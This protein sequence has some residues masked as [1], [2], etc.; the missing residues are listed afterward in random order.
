MLAEA[1]TIMSGKQSMKPLRIEQQ[2]S[3]LKI[4]INRPGKR[5]A[6]TEELI[7]GLADRVSTSKPDIKCVVLTAC[8]EHFSS[9]LDLTELVLRDAYS[10][11]QHA[12]LWHRCLDA[13]QYGSVPVIAALKG[14]V[15]GGGLELA[16]AAHI[17]VA[18]RTTFYALPEGARGMYIGGGGSARIPRLIGVARMTDMML[19]GRVVEADEGQQIGLSQYLVDPAAAISKAME[20]ATR[21]AENTTLTNFA[22]TQV[23]PRIADSSPEAGLLTESLIAGMAQSDPSAKQRLEDFL[24]GRAARVKNLKS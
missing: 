14:A 6:L 17:R 11:T 1:L 8:G 19:T 13:I 2:G 10:G 3:I 22:V 21:I 23:L 12:R 9:G 4:E 24:E 5:N 20:L 16:C 15:I 7:V 18:D